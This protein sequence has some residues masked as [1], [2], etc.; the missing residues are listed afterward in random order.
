MN[1]TV[2][3]C[4]NWISGCWT[5]WGLTFSTAEIFEPFDEKHWGLCWKSTNSYSFGR[6]VVGST[7][8]SAFKVRSNIWHFPSLTL[9]LNSFLTMSPTAISSQ[10]GGIAPVALVMCVFTD[11]TDIDSKFAAIADITEGAADGAWNCSCQR[12]ELSRNQY[13]MPQLYEI[14]FR[15]K[16]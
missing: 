14:A 1:I 16:H 13:N 12:S 7:K 4:R 6:E 9:W 11:S 5:S 3:H 10:G 2:T 8:F 15:I